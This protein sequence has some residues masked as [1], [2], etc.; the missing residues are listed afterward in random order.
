M[1]PVRATDRGSLS[2]E[3]V[4]ITP[5]IFLVFGLIY[6]FGRVASVDN[7]LDTGTRDGARAASFTSTTVQAHDVAERA[8][9]ADLGS[10]TSTC[11]NTLQVTI[12]APGGGVDLVPGTTLTVQASC[13][14]QTA[15]VLYLPGALA[16]GGIDVQSQFSVVV[17]L[18]R[19]LG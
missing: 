12:I 15:D 4:I 14:Y 11:Q 16:P 18:N 13:T 1:S 3:Y 17:D 5:V 10:G 19:S 7:S 8:I 9:K 6:V 2:I